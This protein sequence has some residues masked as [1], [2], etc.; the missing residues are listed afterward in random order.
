VIAVPT[1]LPWATALIQAGGGSV[2]EYGS[3]EWA[4]LDNTDARKVAAC[5][6]AAE[7]WRQHTDPAAVEQRLRY[8]LAGLQD[9]ADRVAEEQEARLTELNHRTIDQA[10]QRLTQPAPGRIER[11]PA[12]KRT[13]RHLRVVSSA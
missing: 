1:P 11:Q 6:L 10:V 5:V 13:G 2:P 7:C 12:P 9:A 8:E 3:A 4:A